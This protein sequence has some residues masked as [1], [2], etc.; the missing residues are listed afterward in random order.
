MISTYVV[1]PAAL[2][3]AGLKALLQGNDFSVV[4]ESASLEACGDAVVETAPDLVLVECPAYDS[5]EF[6]RLLTFKE[7]LSEAR[8]VVLVD[9]LPNHAAQALCDAGVEGLLKTDIAPE[10]LIGYINLVMLGETVVHRAVGAGGRGFAGGRGH[11]G[12]PAFLDR[13]SERELMVIRHLASGMSN[14]EIA[15]V[16]GIMDGTIKIHVRNIQRKLQLKNR[17]QIAVWA[18]ENGVMPAESEDEAA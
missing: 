1:V 7:E 4:G 16:L 6:D 18:V 12:S 11:I 5:E 13:I 3:R 2:Q 8:V 14:K 9:S 17:T 15:R 10:A